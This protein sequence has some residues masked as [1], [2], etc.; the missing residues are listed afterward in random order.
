MLSLLEPLTSIPM[1]KKK[2]I[3]IHEILVYICL[4]KSTLIGERVEKVYFSCFEIPSLELLCSKPLSDKSKS[5]ANQIKY[6]MAFP[7]N[8]TLINCFR[9]Y[10]TFSFLAT[11]CIALGNI[12][13]SYGSK[14][15]LYAN[16]AQT[17]ISV[18][19]NLCLSSRVL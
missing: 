11:L 19:Y 10:I 2:R 6:W 9:I 14:Y 18:L 8:T 7:D 5:S 12:I 16:D 1:E 4:G 13:Y 15:Y 3:N 17:Y